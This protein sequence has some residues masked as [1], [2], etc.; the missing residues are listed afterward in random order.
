MNDAELLA[1][2]LR[3]GSQGENSLSLAKRLLLQFGSLSAILKASL[4]ELQAFKGIGVS[5]WSQLQ[6]IHEL[7]QRTYIEKLKEQDVLSSSALVKN[8]LISLIGH[9]EH[10]VFVCLYLDVHLK[11]ISSQEIFRGSVS[12]TTVHIREIA[13]ECL[14]RNASYLI[15]AHNHP[16]GDLSPSLAD[17]ELTKSLYQALALMDVQLLDHCIVSKQGGISFS[18]LK[19]MTNIGSN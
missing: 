1:V 3:T 10:E 14:L 5:K 19:I 9:K 11:L 13:K 4:H 7:A 12:Q 18:E 15:I 17:I 8:Y 2:I 6:V 16:S